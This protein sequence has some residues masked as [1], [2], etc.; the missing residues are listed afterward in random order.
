MIKEGLD[1]YLGFDSDLLFKSGDIIRIFGGAIRDILSN[2]KIH[3]IDILVAPKSY[4]GVRKVLEDNG[5][6]LNLELIGK[7]VESMYKN[8]RIISEPHTFLKTIDNTIR[9]VQLI[10]PTTPTNDDPFKCMLNVIHN[11]DLSCCGISY[12]SVNLYENYKD[13]ILHCRYMG[14]EVIKESSMYNSD[15][16]IHRTVKLNSR[17]WVNISGKNMTRE[18]NLQILLPDN[19][20]FIE[21]YKKS[22]IRKVSMDKEWS[23]RPGKSQL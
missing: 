3:D 9:I 21:E 2:N 15:R 20:K 17:G 5:F 1:N 16:T 8:I 22:S 7:D 4:I 18:L 11:I 13:A 12:D 14:Y 6:E 23:H 19:L 10:R